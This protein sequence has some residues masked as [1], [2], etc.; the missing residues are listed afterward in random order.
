MPQ[1]VPPPCQD[2][3]LKWF[4]DF[5]FENGSKAKSA[6]LLGMKRYS[7]WFQIFEVYSHIEKNARSARQFVL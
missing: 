5:L 3:K 4:T 6:K 7:I 2:C 1:H